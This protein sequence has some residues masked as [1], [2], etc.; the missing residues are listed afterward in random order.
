MKNRKATA[1]V[2]ALAAGLFTVGAAGM[3]F[4]S[5][6]TSSYSEFAGEG[7]K[8]GDKAPDFTVTDMNGKIHTLSDY[9]KQGKIV[10]LEWFN[11]ECPFVVRVHGK[12]DAMVKTAEANQDKV[13]WIAINS[14]A[15]G[16]QGTEKALNVEKASEWKIAYP[17]VLDESGKIGKMYGAKTTPHMFVIGT[18]GVVAYTGAFDDSGKEIG[19]P[20][21]VA[22]AIASLAAGETIKVTET[23]PKGCPVKYGN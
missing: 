15:P 13:V 9:T 14:G 21:Y 11:P 17:I 20:N 1:L 22:D 5:S 16:K 2:A 19:T 4:A 18:D 8:V 23:T 6:G 10:V 3:A 7:V 12:S